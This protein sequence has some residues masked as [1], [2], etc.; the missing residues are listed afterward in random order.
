[1]ITLE[2]KRLAQEIINSYKSVVDNL[3]KTYKSKIFGLTLSEI[4]LFDENCFD[5]EMESKSEIVALGVWNKICA[6]NSD[7]YRAPEDVFG[8]LKGKLEAIGVLCETFYDWF[9][10][11]E[12]H[13]YAHIDSPAGDYCLGTYCAKVK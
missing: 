9:E 6:T 12:C 10:C 1:M 3:D 5:I 7:S 11:P 8:E 2:T 13:K 4:K